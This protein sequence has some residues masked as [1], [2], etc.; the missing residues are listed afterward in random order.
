MSLHAV[1]NGD[2]SDASDVNQYKTLLQGGTAGQVLTSAGG[3]ADPAYANPALPAVL[4]SG[5]AG[6]VLTSPGGSGPATM[7]NLP[8]PT[9]T[10]ASA[11]L[12][13]DVT[14]MTA[15]TWNDIVSVS[16]GAGTWLVWA[17]VVLE[18]TSS[19]QA[20][21]VR[22]YDGTTEFGAAAVTATAASEEQTVTIASDLVVEVGTVTLK[23]QANPSA[24]GWNALAA[25]NATTQPKCT[26]IRALR[27]A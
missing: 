2:A 4:S 7:Q 21:D 25:T 12:G 6:Q 3:G 10:T 26:Y 13:S 1:T 9:P 8:Y 11:N 19:G 5:T 16:L 14:G 15:S 24:S 22:V 18:N 20:C 17:G 23:L 27:V